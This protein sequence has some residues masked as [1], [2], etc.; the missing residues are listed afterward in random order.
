MTGFNLLVAVASLDDCDEDDHDE[1]SRDE[2]GRDEDC[3]GEHAKAINKLPAITFGDESHTQIYLRTRRHLF[4][5][6]KFAQWAT[7]PTNPQRLR[8]PTRYSGR[9]LSDMLS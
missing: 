9:S 4:F 8:R 2:S 7:Y 6:F 1:S 5:I 3:G